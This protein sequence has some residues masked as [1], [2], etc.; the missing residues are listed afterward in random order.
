[1]GLPGSVYD[2]EKV[3]GKVAG[4]GAEQEWEGADWVFEF[5]ILIY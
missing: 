5:F 2:R 1:M 3:Y 4:K